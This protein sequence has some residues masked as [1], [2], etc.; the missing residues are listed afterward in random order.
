[1]SILKISDAILSILRFG[2]ATVLAINTSVRASSVVLL[3]MTRAM[4][5]IAVDLEMPAKQFIPRL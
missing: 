4:I 3:A 1:M 2:Q 5:P